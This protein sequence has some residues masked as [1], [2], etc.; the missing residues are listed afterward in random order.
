L[1]ESASIASGFPTGS[2]RKAAAK[3][4]RLKI[5][6]RKRGLLVQA[7]DKPGVVARI[8]GELAAVN[9]NVTAID[10]VAGGKGR[11][12]AILWVKPAAFARAS[13]ALRAVLGSITR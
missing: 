7:D 13:K 4:L 1:W 6:A 9:I 11:H 5:S 8:M 10:A 2:G 12:G 3:K